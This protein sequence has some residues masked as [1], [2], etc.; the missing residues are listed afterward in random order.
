[1]S[2]GSVGKVVILAISPA[3]FLMMGTVNGQS[4]PQCCESYTP[5]GGK[6]IN[7]IPGHKE[8]CVK[9]PALTD[10]VEI[11]IRYLT[12]CPEQV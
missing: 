12:N 10:N 6:V 5:W 9:T 1:M 2:E 8:N 11:L 3:L 4:F 7:F